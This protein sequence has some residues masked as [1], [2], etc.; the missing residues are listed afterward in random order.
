MIVCVDAYVSAPLHIDENGMI[1]EGVLV[2]LRQP[3]VFNI[4]S[5]LARQLVDQ[6]ASPIAGFSLHCL[7]FADVTLA[8][9]KIL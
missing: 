7:Q 2:S 5:A 4:Q 3:L 8:A 6:D 1:N 9:V